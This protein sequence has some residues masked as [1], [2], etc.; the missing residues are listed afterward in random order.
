MMANLLPDSRCLN[1]KGLI[2]SKAGTWVPIFCANCNK[3]SG[4]VP[5]E[6]TTFAFYLCNCCV[7]TH[8]AMANTLM[9][10]DE[11]F[12][13]EVAAEQEVKQQKGDL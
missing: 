9:V 5:E 12:W 6:N 4:M 7:E 1:P 2:R 3:P 11:V 13:A 10:P 8:G